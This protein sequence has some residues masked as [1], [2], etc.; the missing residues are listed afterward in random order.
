MQVKKKAIANAEEMLS[1]LMK[2][3]KSQSL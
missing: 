3:K 2:E 1:T